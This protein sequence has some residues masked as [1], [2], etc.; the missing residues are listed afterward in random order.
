MIPQIEWPDDDRS[1]RY[2]TGD[3]IHPNDQAGYIRVGDKV[4]F[5]AAKLGKVIDGEVVEVIP[6]FDLPSPEL[7][8]AIASGGKRSFNR[9]DHT[10]YA[11][12][13]SKTGSIY[14]PYGKSAILQSSDD[15]RLEAYTLADVAV[16]TKKQVDDV[17]IGRRDI[18]KLQELTETMQKSFAEFNEVLARLAAR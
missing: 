16:V 5:K 17:K 8:E 1:A 10:R 2:R 7:M 14:I 13:C 3:S 4:S 11:V 6:P 18:K 12:R 15:F 9:C